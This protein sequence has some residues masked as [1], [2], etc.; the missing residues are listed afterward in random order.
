[1]AVLRIPDEKRTIT[2]PVMLT[3][4]LAEVGIDYERWEPSHPVALGAP[5]AEVLEAYRDE[6]ERLKALGGY[7]T[8]DVIDVTAA[9][10]GLDAMLAKFNREHWHDEDEVR[11]IV[12][13]S[14]L[15]HV[16]PRDGKVLAIEVEAG[17]LVRVPRGTWHWFDLC[18]SRDIRAIRLFQDPAG[19]SPHYTESGAEAGFEPVCLGLEQMPTR[20][21]TL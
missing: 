11:F 5:A 7:V 9:T 16:R 20:G 15:F 10:P 12:R 2:D 3:A 4:R 13:G 8:A 21:A 18:A 19:W 6:I 1:M 14:G 17:D